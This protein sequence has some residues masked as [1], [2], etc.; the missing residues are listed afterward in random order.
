MLINLALGVRLG[1]THGAVAMTTLLAAGY[2]SFTAP[3]W[4]GLDG[5]NLKLPDPIYNT[6]IAAAATVENSYEFHTLKCAIDTVAD[7]EAVDMN[8][9][10]APGVTHDGLTGHMIDVC[11]ERADALAIIDLASVY[12]PPHEAYHASKANRIAADPGS[13]RHRFER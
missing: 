3:F 2:D 13:T 7:P 6:G 4:G 1:S 10:L 5:W 8:L 11:E 12:I 9:L